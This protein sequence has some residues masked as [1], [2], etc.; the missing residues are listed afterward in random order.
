MSPLGAAD[1][2]HKQNVGSARCSIAAMR[3]SLLRYESRSGRCSKAAEAGPSCKTVVPFAPC[4]SSQTLRAP[5]W[6]RR[7]RST[8]SRG[9]APCPRAS[10]CQ[11][12]RAS[13]PRQQL[14][15]CGGREPGACAG[16]PASAKQRHTKSDR[17]VGSS[18]KGSRDCCLWGS[19]EGSSVCVTYLQGKHDLLLGEPLLDGSVHLHRQTLEGSHMQHERHVLNVDALRKPRREQSQQQ[20]RQPQKCERPIIAVPSSGSCLTGRTRRRPSCSSRCRRAA[21]RLSCALCRA[22][23]RQQ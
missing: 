23:R 3:C 16:S 9:T 4:G 7:L 21:S 17:S 5:G 20:A 15:P 13:P 18:A 11:G 6:W 12:S 14:A 19:R 8:W 22:H 2:K 10:G 1:A